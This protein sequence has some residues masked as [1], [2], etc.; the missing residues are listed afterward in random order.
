MP[1]VLPQTYRGGKTGKVGASDPFPFFATSLHQI[2]LSKSGTLSSPLIMYLSVF[3]EYKSW[4]FIAVS[5]NFPTH[6]FKLLNQCNYL[7]K[8]SLLFGLILRV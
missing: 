5:L 8:N 7:L 1:V 4:V 2:R 6:T 3:R